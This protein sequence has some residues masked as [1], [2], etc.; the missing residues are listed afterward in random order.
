MPPIPPSPQCTDT[1]FSPVTSDLHFPPPLDTVRAHSK[2]DLTRCSCSVRPSLNSFL[3]FLQSSVPRFTPTYLLL[4][5]LDVGCILGL[6]L[7]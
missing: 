7:T 3:F 4:C 5:P 1:G 6:L 2:P